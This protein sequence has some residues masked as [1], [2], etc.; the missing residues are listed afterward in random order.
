[1]SES[2]RVVKIIAESGNLFDS[3]VTNEKGYRK[4]LENGCLWIVFPQTGRLLPYCGEEKF[5]QIAEVNDTIEVRYSEKS[6]GK[7]VENCGKPVENVDKCTDNSNLEQIPSKKE[8]NPQP[9]II[10]ESLLKLEKIIQERHQS[11]PEGSY[12]THLFRSGKEKIRKKTGEEAVELILAKE[13][14]EIIYEA[15]DLLYHLFVLLES[16]EIRLSEIVDE[17]NSRP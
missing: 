6:V 9:F 5:L 4:S 3:V 8:E 14:K 17:L 15:A 7:F 13:K 10:G 11:L 1:M 2:L 12:T 16:E